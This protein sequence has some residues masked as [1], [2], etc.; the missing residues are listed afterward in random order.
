MKAR[1]K[2]RIL[3][4]FG[5][6]PSGSSTVSEAIHD[7]EQAMLED[8]VDL[9]AVDVAK[10]TKIFWDSPVLGQRVDAVLEI[11]WAAYLG[12]KPM[13]VRGSVTTDSSYE[14]ILICHCSRADPDSARNISG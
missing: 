4:A 5:V 1:A 10:F 2:L 13:Q 11:G 14:L 7:A 6:G 8:N 12:G 3:G 9:Y